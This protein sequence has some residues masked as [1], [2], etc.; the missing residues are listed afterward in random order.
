M[1]QVPTFPELEF[2]E[3]RHIY[4]LNGLAI[5]AVSTVMKPL[6]EAYYG[7][8][9]GDILAAAA[10]RGTTVH[11]AIE[12]HLKYGI[13]DIPPEHEGYYAAYKAWWMEKTPQLLTTESRV[14]HRV[15]RYAGT[16]DLSCILDG[17]EKVCVDFKT[18]AQIIEMLVRVQLEAYDRAFVS[19]SFKH[20]AKAIVQLKKDGQWEMKMFP[21]NDTEAWEV[22]GGLLTVHN[23][24]SKYRR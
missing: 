19:H 6:S 16:S 22:F 9:D 13:D 1:I 10:K 11:Q 12:N 7:S 20:D 2:E 17:G 24:L 18:S 14:Y 5:P 21:S 15:L 23:Y 3:T 8:I 4:K